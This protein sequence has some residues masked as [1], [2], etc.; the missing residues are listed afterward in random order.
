METQVSLA[1]IH[2]FTKLSTHNIMTVAWQNQCKEAFQQ[3]RMYLSLILD[4]NI[5]VYS[6]SPPANT[7][8]HE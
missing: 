7:K 4:V 2:K 8:Q 5:S 1:Y 6:V 3:I